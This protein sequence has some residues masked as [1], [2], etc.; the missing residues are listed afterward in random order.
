MYFAFVARAGRHRLWRRCAGALLGTLHSERHVWSLSGVCQRTQ[1]ILCRLA[2]DCRK[3][4]GSLKTPNAR[5][6]GCALAR[7]QALCSPH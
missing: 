4:Q 7:L 6:L 2:A 3:S 5:R 1:A